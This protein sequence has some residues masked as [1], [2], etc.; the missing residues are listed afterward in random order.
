ME[1]LFDVEAGDEHIVEGAI[2]V[3]GESTPVGDCMSIRA[4]LASSSFSRDDREPT[5]NKRFQFTD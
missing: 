4:S 2:V 1:V 5:K 3:M